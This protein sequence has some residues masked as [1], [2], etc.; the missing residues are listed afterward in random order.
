MSLM[1]SD[2]MADVHVWIPMQREF[3]R[4]SEECRKLYESLQDKICDPN[5]FDFICKNTFFYL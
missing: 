1:N 4:Y 5:S 2:D 3:Y